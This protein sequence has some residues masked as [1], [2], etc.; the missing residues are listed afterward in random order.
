M[1]PMCNV[2]PTPKHCI[3]NSCQTFGDKAAQIINF[4]T[5]LGRSVVVLETVSFS[6]KNMLLKGKYLG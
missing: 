1:S 3:M 2:I 4:G 6:T 5:L